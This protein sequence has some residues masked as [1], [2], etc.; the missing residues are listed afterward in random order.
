MGIFFDHGIVYLIP[1]L[2]EE[3]GHYKTITINWQKFVI[4]ID[5]RET[6]ERLMNMEMYKKNSEDWT[7]LNSDFY[8]HFD[9]VKEGLEI[10]TEEIEKINRVE[11]EIGIRG[12]WYEVNI[13]FNTYN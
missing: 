7:S 13:V 2:N 11:K 5:T 10:S 3:T 8:M 12:N 6:D 4:V 9:P 1:I